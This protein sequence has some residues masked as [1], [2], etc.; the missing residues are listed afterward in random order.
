MTAETVSPRRAALV[1][2]M[3]QSKLDT[4]T[5]RGCSP[6]RGWFGISAGDRGQRFGPL[7]VRESIPVS[8]HL[9]DRLADL[10]VGHVLLLRSVSLADVSSMAHVNTPVNTPDERFQ[11]N[12]GR[13]VTPW[14]SGT[15]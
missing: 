7:L 10:G 14:G 8:E 15:G 9:A 6:G 11:E 5:A 4:R 13:V 12:F 1:L 3:F 2:A